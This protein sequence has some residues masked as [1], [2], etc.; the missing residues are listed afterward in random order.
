MEQQ[1]E[2]NEVLILLKALGAAFMFTVVIFLLYAVILTYTPVTEKYIPIVAISTT[3]L[4]TII[5]GFDNAKFAKSKGLL[6]GIVAGACYV[7]VLL[8]LGMCVG[9]GETF[10][11]GKLTTIAIALAGGGVGGVIGINKGN[12]S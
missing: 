3:A 1:T 11:L 2:G 6:R 12:A 10:D 4:S 5:A 7:L 9:K 8:I